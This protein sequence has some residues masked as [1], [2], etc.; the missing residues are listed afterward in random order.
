MSDIAPEAPAFWARIPKLGHNKDQNYDFVRSVDVVDTMREIISAVG[1]AYA[2]DVVDQTVYGP[3]PSGKLLLTE[4]TM[5]H[6]YCDV[7]TGYERS[8]ESRG[9]GSDSNDKGTYKAQTGAEKYHLCKLFLIPTGDDPEDHGKEPEG[10]T[11]G[12]G[13]SPPDGDDF[14]LPFEYKGQPKGATLRGIAAEGEAE[15]LAAFSVNYGL[16]AKG[17]ENPKFS[18]KNKA[19]RKLAE[20]LVKAAEKSES[21]PQP[22]AGS[23]PQFDADGNIVW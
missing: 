7:E 5:R 19:A 11:H 20:S 21:A 6:T 4:V 13:Q 9:Q 12:S 15:W 18:A 16:N 17:E 8:F 1:L 14:T 23:E 22:E 2:C 10:K 3:G